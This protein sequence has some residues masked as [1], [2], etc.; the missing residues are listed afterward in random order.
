MTTS[1][2]YGFKLP[3]YEDFADVKDLSDNWEE[4]DTQ[5]KR[6]DDKAGTTLT[7][8]SATETITVSDT[9]GTYDDGTIIFS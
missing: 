1:T 4:L 5:L 8:S 6:V 2:N 9:H 3:E 7:Y